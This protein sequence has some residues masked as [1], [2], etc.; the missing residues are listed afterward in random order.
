[1][2]WKEN[3]KSTQNCHNYLRTECIFQLALCYNLCV[4]LGAIVVHYCEMIVECGAW[5]PIQLDLPWMAS[6]KTAWLTSSNGRTELIT[7][8]IK[9]SIFWWKTI[10]PDNSLRNNP[11]NYCYPLISFY[12]FNS[13][14]FFPQFERPMCLKP[15][16]ITRLYADFSVLIIA[17]KNNLKCTN[18]TI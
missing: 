11:P 2:H 10:Q 7:F 8:R 3:I 14:I 1:M 5:K 6:L 15:V 13:G 16:C 17:T 9:C 18:C 12:F 4:C